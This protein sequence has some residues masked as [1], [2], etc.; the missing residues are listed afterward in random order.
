MKFYFQRPP[1]DASF[2]VEYLENPTEQAI[3]FKLFR[4]A[5][6][7]GN[8]DV[9][10]DE[11]TFSL[12][13]IF[14]KDFYAL[15]PIRDEKIL[16]PIN[17]EEYRGQIGATEQIQKVY[18]YDAYACY[19][20]FGSEPV[21]EKVSLLGLLD[22]GKEASQVRNSNEYMD[23]YQIVE[24]AVDD[25]KKIKLDAQK[26][27]TISAISTNEVL[28]GVEAQLDLLSK[29]FVALVQEVEHL[30]ALPI[31]TLGEVD[32]RKFSELLRQTSVLNV[33][34]VPSA[35]DEMA[36]QKE[37]IRKEQE[38]YFIERKRIQSNLP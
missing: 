6:E 34:T 14:V 30:K 36:A 29:M 28:T 17:M 32:I 1:K 5:K 26:R 20:I 35:L 9:L 10:L 19:I 11:R 23:F 15:L 24:L 18:Q 21:K 4:R 8:A 13:D 38:R 22:F 25:P 2:R 16:E 3:A 7:E 31:E 37:K 27:S 12:K 33:K